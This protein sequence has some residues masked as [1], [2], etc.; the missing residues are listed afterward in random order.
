LFVAI[1]L[2]TSGS[3][4]IRDAVPLR[5]QSASPATGARN[6]AFEVASVKVTSAGSFSMSPYGLNR[7]SLR[8]VSLTLLISLAYGV[9]DDQISGG[10]GWRNSEYYDVAAKAED[11]V[12]LT[13]DELRPRLQA[14][15]VQ[16]FKL[17]THRAMK[18]SPGYA[19]VVA[20]GGARLKRSE[21]EKATSGSI[22]PG[23]LRAPS[24]S[25]D[26][27]AGMVARVVGRPVVNETGLNGNYEVALD[28]APE[29]VADSPLP[30]IF[31]ALQEQLGLMLQSRAVPVESIV[32]DRVEHPTED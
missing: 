3:V 13:Y 7:F 6:V 2:A 22:L 1:L 23:G 19:L 14:L 10:P 29:A 18:Q 30:S 27:F 26:T 16:R 21:T 11:G 5:A 25:M 8:S 20:T 9:S 17:A 12:M 4:G 28:Y 15:L 31:T 32:I 24:A